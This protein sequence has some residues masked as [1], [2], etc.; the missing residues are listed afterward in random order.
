MEVIIYISAIVHTREL[1]KS[2]YIGRKHDLK[3]TL[4]EKNP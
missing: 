4:H 3:S 2:V 1:K